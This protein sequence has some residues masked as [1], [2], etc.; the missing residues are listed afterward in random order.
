MKNNKK[1]IDV[2]KEVASHGEKFTKG[3]DEYLNGLRKKLADG[4][5]DKKTAIIELK[6]QVELASD[7][8]EELKV[9]QKP[10]NR[11]K[12]YRDIIMD[13][14]DAR[15]VLKKEID[16][17][18]NDILPESKSKLPNKQ[19]Q[20]IHW[21]KGVESLRLFL[22]SIKK[23]SL[24]ENREADEIIQEHFYVDGQEPTKEPQPIKWLIESQYLAYMMH[25]LA[26]EFIINIKGK[27][28]Q[29]TAS[30]FISS[31][32]KALKSLAS[33]LSHIQKHGR[34]TNKNLSIIE[35]IIQKVNS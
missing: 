20:P 26:E 1:F 7:Y 28:H 18:E 32:G 19:I 4:E 22:Q 30:H 14:K 10:F 33:Q 13:C 8:L 35:N 23:D 34:S 24:I 11:F 3:A 9:Y 17:Y 27:K 12:Q 5:I 29:L 6:T 2:L 31:K 15:R 16:L 21:N 25:R